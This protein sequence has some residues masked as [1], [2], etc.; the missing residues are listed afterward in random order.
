MLRFHIYLLLLILLGNNFQLNAQE[1]N[2]YEFKRRLD[3]SLGMVTIGAGTASFF[4]QKKKS[5]L[6]EES[7]SQLSIMDINRFDRSAAKRSWN[8]RINLSSDIG[9]MFAIASPALLLI[10]KKMRNE[11][12][13]IVPMW[14]E[15]FALTQALTSMTKELVQ[16]ERPYTYNPDAP[17]EEKLKKDARSSFF[18]GHTSQTAA[19]AF[20][21]AKVFSDLN[22]NSKWKPLVWTGAVALPLT[23]GALRYS[24]GKHFFTDI[25]V[26]Y[27]IGAAVGILVPHLHQA[28]NSLK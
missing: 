21:T 10:D 15:T 5:V 14:L 26:G 12:K 6:T 2:V 18:S 28:K 19:N 8:E 22:P 24:G 23:V 7:I 25:L 16:R 13:V 17:L 9:L 4:L 3:I 20:F 1:T 27:A 11:A